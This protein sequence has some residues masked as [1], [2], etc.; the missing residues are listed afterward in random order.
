MYAGSEVQGVCCC[1]LGAG[2]LTEGGG[3]SFFARARLKAAAA[4]L[5]KFGW[6]PSVTH[7]L[8]RRISD[9]VGDLLHFT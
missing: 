9:E 3:H 8:L 1:F 7:V 4:P 5:L 2:R 6:G